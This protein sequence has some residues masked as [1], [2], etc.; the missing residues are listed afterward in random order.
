[1]SALI[2]ASAAQAL[3]PV[4][5]VTPPP[6]SPGGGP[7]EPPSAPD[8][9]DATINRLEL[10][11]AAMA[12]EQAE[13][14]T[15]HEQALAA[16][17]AEGMRAGAAQSATREADR[18]AAVEDA[19]VLAQAAFE[20]RLDALE[21]LAPALASRALGKLVDR[22]DWH[23]LVTETVASQVARLRQTVVGVRVAPDLIEPVTARGIA[24]VA[25]DRGLPDGTAHIVCA[26]GEVDVDVG[27]AVA[28]LIDR[29]DDLVVGA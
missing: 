24:N 20:A 21:A 14:A 13:A 26:L 17:R 27:S 16:A 28:A 19:I 6:S 10:A 5:I 2:K 22:I 9:R 18:C 15:A 25:V 29:L 23:D 4:R 7:S 8:P 12:E 3:R 1:M 11:L